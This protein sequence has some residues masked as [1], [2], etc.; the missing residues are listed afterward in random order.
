MCKKTTFSCV[1]SARGAGLR[2]RPQSVKH[3]EALT[4]LTGETSPLPSQELFEPFHPCTSFSIRILNK[5]IVSENIG[6]GP[7]Y[8]LFCAADSN[9]SDPQI[10][11]KTRGLSLPERPRECCNMK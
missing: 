6:V 8:G 10:K 2:W 5:E 1:S 7:K 11:S 9:E 4:E 3:L